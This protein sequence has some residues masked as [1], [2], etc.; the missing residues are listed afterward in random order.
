[1]RDLVHQHG[2]QLE[3]VDTAR[4]RLRRL[5]KEIEGGRAQHQERAGPPTCP[6]ARV[7]LRPQ[8][9]EDLGR[10]LNLVEHDQPIAGARQE[11]LGVEELGQVE[12]ALEI[13]VDRSTVDRGGVVHGQRGLAHLTRAKQ[14]DGGELG[15]PVPERRGNAPRNHY[16]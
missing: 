5:S 7:D 15:E 4:E 2:R 16:M 11:G 13:E 6:P 3:V 12:R 14:G 10:A 1:M 8:D 9:L